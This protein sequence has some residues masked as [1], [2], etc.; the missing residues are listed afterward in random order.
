[1]KL[2]K[3]V[4]LPALYLHQCQSRFSTCTIQHNLLQL[5]QAQRLSNS[6]LKTGAG[7]WQAQSLSNSYLKTGAGKWQAQ[8]LSNSYLKNRSWEMA[9]AEFEQ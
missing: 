1:V 5:W 8:S 9:G 3:L 2:K 4:I 6:Y 7:K